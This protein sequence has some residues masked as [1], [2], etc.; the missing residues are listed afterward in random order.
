MTVTAWTDAV[1]TRPGPAVRFVPPT[2]PR[3]EPAADT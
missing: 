3:S 1:A 2:L